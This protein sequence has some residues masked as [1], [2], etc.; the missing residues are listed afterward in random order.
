MPVQHDDARLPAPPAVTKVTRPA[1]PAS[2]SAGWPDTCR[3]DLGS[4]DAVLPAAAARRLCAEAGPP[5]ARAGIDH[6]TLATW[7]RGHRDALF[8]WASALAGNPP[9]GADPAARRIFATTAVALQRQDGPVRVVSWLFGEALL[10]AQRHA[11]RGRLAEPLLTGLP[12]ELR[13]ML[14]LVAQGELR[15]EEAWAL[16]PQ[17]MGFVRRRLVKARLTP[18]SLTSALGN[19]SAADAT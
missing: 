19:I 9:L 8:R 5:A 18:H 15:A 2:L 16:L 12:P 4:L 7:L 14:R 11:V 17:P 6:V 10:A 13:A 1:W 3:G